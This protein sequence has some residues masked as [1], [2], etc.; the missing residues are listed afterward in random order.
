M[1]WLSFD[2]IYTMTQ[3][4]PLVFI[5]YPSSRKYFSEYIFISF[6]KIGDVG[7]DNTTIHF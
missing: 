1:G 4:I 5:L 7:L 6:E 3:Q 2:F